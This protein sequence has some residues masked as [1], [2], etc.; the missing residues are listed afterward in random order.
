MTGR[1]QSSCRVPHSRHTHTVTN[2]IGGHGTSN[3]SNHRAL[4]RFPCVVVV[5]SDCLLGRPI[6]IE[7][8]DRVTTL[9]KWAA[10]RAESDQNA[11]C[12][13]EA[14]VRK[15]KIASLEGLWWAGTMSHPMFEGVAE[16]SLFGKGPFHS[17]RKMM[18]TVS[19]LR[20]PISA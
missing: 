12:F 18:Q 19:I 4:Q 5:T 1:H 8:S 16:V 6:I 14:Y 7:P 11:K 15:R 20:L 2:G 17:N 9:V 13:S 3:K 10:D